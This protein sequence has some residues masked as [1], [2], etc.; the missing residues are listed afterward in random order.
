MT[1]KKKEPTKPKGSQR[2]FGTNAVEDFE[3]FRVSCL[4]QP[5]SSHQQGL[6][7]R[8]TLRS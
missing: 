4:S 5:L 2:T 1:S 6:G 8:P 3:K 7:A